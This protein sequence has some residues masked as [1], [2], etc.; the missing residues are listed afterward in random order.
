M[1]Q[2]MLLFTIKEIEIKNIIRYYYLH[3]K[4]TKIKKTISSAGEESQQLK[5]PYMAEENAE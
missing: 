1:F 4:M 3:I 2:W 5:I